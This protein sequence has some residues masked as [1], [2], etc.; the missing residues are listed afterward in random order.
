MTAP[1]AGIGING[2]NL[3]FLLGLP[4]SGTTLLAEMLGNDPKILAPPEPWL[5]FA[6]LEIGCVGVRH[7][8]GSQSI[9]SAV[10]RFLGDDNLRKAQR[11]FA[12]EAYNT[13]LADTGCAI[14]LDKTP[15]YYQIAGQIADL[16]PAA[17][18]II[19][20]RN[21]VNVA[22]S[23][24][25]SW[26]IDPFLLMRQA[27]DDPFVFDLL[28]G[29][30]L[31]DRFAAYFPER[32]ITVHYEALVD[33]PVK[34]LAEIYDFI[35][36]KRSNRQ[37]AEQIKLSH[38]RR[39]DGDMGDR[40]ILATQAVH[41]QS[42]DT[43]RSLA[44]EQLAQLLGWIGVDVVTDWGYAE[45]V[46]HAAASGM[47]VPDP[48][49]AGQYRQQAQR[50]YDT[51]IA[52]QIRAASLAQ[53]LSEGEQ[54]DLGFIFS[55]SADYVESGMRG[56][57]ANLLA[58]HVALKLEAESIGRRLVAM[59]ADLF[60]R[61][62]AVETLT[63][64][65]QEAEADRTARGQAMDLLTGQLNEAEKDRADRIKAIEQ[66]GRQLREAETD[67]AD[68]ARA[69]ETLS[70]QLEES[71]AD[72]TARA[73]AIDK[74]TRQL[75][76]AEADRADRARAIEQL[77]RQLEE[78]EADRTARAGAI[79]EL[80]R[81][82]R[83]AEADRA[84]RA[85]AIEQLS[86]QLEE[87]EA[88]RSARAGAIETLSRQLQ[89]S[90]ADRAARGAAIDKL[91]LQLQ[92]AELDHAEAI[93]QLVTQLQ[94]SE[95]DRAARGEAMEKLSALLEVAEADRAARLAAV[96]QLEALLRESEA[97]RAARGKAIEQLTA[98]LKAKP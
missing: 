31:L 90:E 16:F 87:S 36:R 80:T 17:R 94:E 30:R 49:R 20:R 4:R 39:A 95:I 29:P 27:P 19:L 98:W 32:Q 64:Q 52:D 25:D 15:R 10:R 8:A 21:P 45:M 6:A 57:L 82:L 40:K 59:E 50:L 13:Q 89:E 58:E 44:P 28:L 14:F 5:M 85:R 72:R 33:D 48:R 61:G 84:D 70:R 93:K 2:E 65:L 83:E 55:G 34:L 51:R 35:G 38:K 23:Y 66:L 18:F 47:P 92:A 67:R 79:D 22:L 76:E 9:G 91:G 62:T 26:N 12:R 73:G 56:R 86:R 11:D 74:L 71:E 96:N 3:L 77:S 88:D 53:P 68:R 46:Q 97:D 37:L 78:S 69:I 1:A 7:P 42:R 43:W 63:R 41:R 81:Q 60:A 54:A 24:R 75:R